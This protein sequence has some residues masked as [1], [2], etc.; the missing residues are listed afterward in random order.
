MKMPEDNT[1]EWSDHKNWTEYDWEIAMRQS[2]EFA[3]KYFALLEKYGE[4]P[5]SDDIILQKI[6]GD[7]L[8]LSEFQDEGN[9]ING[10]AE[11][12]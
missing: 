12:F 8:S 2:D 5:G 9:E 4:L 10:V 1:P 6:D 11:F 3:S 7:Q